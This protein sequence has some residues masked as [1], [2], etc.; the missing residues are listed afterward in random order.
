MRGIAA[1]PG[2]AD[3]STGPASYDQELEKPFSAFQE[4][5]GSADS[6]V[7][8]PPLKEHCLL[9]GL[10]GNPGKMLHHF[11]ACKRRHRT[12]SPPEGKGEGSKYKSLSFRVK[13][14][15][16]LFFSISLSYGKRPA[17]AVMLSRKSMNIAVT[18]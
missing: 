7:V 1:M 10:C 11:P 3:I 14:G 12:K 18:K 13:F 15:A 9:L 16:F 5:L 6:D 2:C 4:L 8:H 17:T